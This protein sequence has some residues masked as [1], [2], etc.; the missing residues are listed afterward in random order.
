[1]SLTDLI[2]RM[3]A[4]LCAGLLLAYVFWQL[5][6][7]YR[8]P[9]TQ[10]ESAQYLK[11]LAVCPLPSSARD[12]LIS[13]ARRFMAADDG[14]PVYMLNLMRYHDQ[15]VKAPGGPAFGG[16][17]REANALYESLTM[18]M[19]F[20]H[21]GQPLYAGEIRDDNLLMQA[22]DLNHWNRLLIIRYPSRRAFMDLVTDPAYAPAA[23]Y[24]IMA[25]DVVLTPSGPEI[26]LPVLWTVA[27][28]L[29][30]VLLRIL[31]VRNCRGER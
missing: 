24:K 6:W 19:L 17:P 3:A 7:L 1:M 14:K 25:L 13:S 16:T 31:L 11:T 29:L 27:L 15:L 18:P 10:A 5:P 2:R 8:E 23:P 22:P 21:G 9:I 12:E 20:R 4:W 30:C 26:V 28:L